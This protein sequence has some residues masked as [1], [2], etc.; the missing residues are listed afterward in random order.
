[1]KEN[2]QN[3]SLLKIQNTSSSN[4]GHEQLLK[5]IT[6]TTEIKSTINKSKLKSSHKTFS[7]LLKINQKGQGLMEYIILVALIAVTSI[8]VVKVLGH[9]LAVQYENINRSLGAKT[10]SPLK[11]KNASDSA[12]KQKDL[13]NFMDASRSSSR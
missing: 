4:L 3:K 9:N 6:A 5:N 8:G 2:N 11:V 13:S 10:N 1:M 12:L 7:Q